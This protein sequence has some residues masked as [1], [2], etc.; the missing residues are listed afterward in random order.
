MN[1]ENQKFSLTTYL[2][3]YMKKI[4]FFL[5]GDKWRYKIKPISWYNF[6]LWL[7]DTLSEDW[8]RYKASSR[9]FSLMRFIYFLRPNLVCPLFIVG[10]PR[11]GTTF[12]GECVAE[13]PE[14]S[15]HFE[16]VLTKAAT[17]YVYEKRWSS[18]FSI[19]F[20]KWVYSWL[21]RIHFDGDLRF[22][23]KTPQI[24]LIVPFLFQAFPDARFIYIVRDGRD[25]AISLSKKLWYQNKMQGSGAKEPGG[26]PLGPKAR[27]WV[28]DDRIFEFETT[29]DLH[30]CV[31]LWRRYVEIISTS[32]KTLP[33]SSV[34]EIKYENLV[35]N[36]K[37]EATKIL[38]F[39]GI[40]DSYSRKK[41]ENYLADNAKASSVRR[42]EN[43]LS[44]TQ[45]R[46]LESEAGQCLKMYNYL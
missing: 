6:P 31:W 2:K 12:L 21:M 10:A 7:W 23:E 11:S 29:N 24:S 33:E 39:I 18:S 30:R 22:A 41:F 34:L 15:Y 45:L 14:L 4:R 28:E 8:K 43:E 17:R 32:L 1:Q 44:L 27:F 5:I 9:P 13:L 20:F 38:D 40:V 25:S 26:Y 46:E 35:K 42:W 3:N 36:P 19:F 37:I 16:P